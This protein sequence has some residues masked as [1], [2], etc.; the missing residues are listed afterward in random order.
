MTRAWLILPVITL[1]NCGYVGDPLPPAAKI[2]KP[3][4]D[5]R[6]I[7]RGDKLEVVFT[8]PVVTGEGLPVREPGQIDLRIGPAPA[9][10]FDVNAWLAG[11][12][13][14][15]VE[16][17]PL[18]LAPD[19]TAIARTITQAFD[20]EPWAGKEVVIGVRLTSPSGRPSGFSNFVAAEVIPPLR[21]PTSFTGE[22]RGDGILLRWPAVA[23][24]GV[25]YRI[26]RQIG[27][28]EPQTIADT[29]ENQFLDLVTA[30]GPT[31]RY[32]LQSYVKAG[33]I[34][35]LSELSPVMQVVHVD[36]FAPAVPT[37]LVVLAGATSVELGWDRNTDADL[38]GYRIYRALTN[39]EFV[40][41][42]G[43]IDA[44][45]FRDTTTKSGQRYRYA[46]TAVDRAGNESG[47]SEPAE[48]E[49]P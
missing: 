13:S 2:P 24:P 45:A 41:F 18:A 31:Y 30:F 17:P 46:I 49:A 40:R 9:P 10:P 7:E 11:S 12:Q 14:I 42:P 39:G 47:R 33:D 19:G 34:N 35:A 44:P 22:S 32:T 36:R 28:G 6:V 23:Q 15:F 37:G 21:K 27:E 8:M 16:W 3:V 5:L 1:V 25:A 38:A 4:L 20:A 43:E 29:P 26:T 48:I